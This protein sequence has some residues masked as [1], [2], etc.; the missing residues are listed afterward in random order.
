MADIRRIT[1]WRL[2]ATIGPAYDAL[3]RA[4]G[5]DGFGPTVR[6]CVD[7]L[8]AGARRLYLFEVAERG[9]DTL[10]Y[11]H[12][13]PR[14]AQLLAAYS[15]HYK[16]LDPIS[17]LYRAAARPGDM[18]VQRLRPSDI[19]SAGFR[20]R[21]FDEPD[22]VE[23][24]SLVVRG[25]H[26]WSGLN[27]ARHASDGRCSDQELDTLVGVARLALPM[28]HLAGSRRAPGKPLTAAHLEDRF[29]HLCPGLTA[30]ER[31][32]CA[33]AALGMSVEATAIE[34]KVAKTSVVTFRRRAY[35]RLQVTSPFELCG[36]V[37][38]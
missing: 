38:N 24:V 32:V 7:T 16:L 20:R 28:L 17:D 31:Q 26:G 8:T 37:A 36:L 27:V 11:H 25:P 18:A 22:I 2:P 30:R 29:A 15:L 23:R 14:I 10:V 35:R 33:R 6:H 13:E 19:G 9:E 1:D 12:C 3:V 21:F 4:M 34:L 5:S